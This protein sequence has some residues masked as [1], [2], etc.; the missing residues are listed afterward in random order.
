MGDYKTRE[1]VADKLRSITLSMLPRAKPDMVTSE[2]SFKRD[3]GA[4]SLDMIELAMNV[5]EDFGIELS[6]EQLDECK[7]F[8]FGQMADRIFEILQQQN[9][10]ELT[11][12]QE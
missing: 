6:D 3:I 9:N 10:A 1:E 7:E 2:A 4:D 5:E 12:Q 11:A 8:S